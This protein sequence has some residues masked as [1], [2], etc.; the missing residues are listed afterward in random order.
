MRPERAPDSFH[1][2]SRTHTKRKVSTESL[3]VRSGPALMKWRQ[4]QGISRPLF[5][6]M[7]DF[8]E[9]K[10]ATYERAAT[11]PPSVRRPIKE[12]VRLIQALRELAGDDEAL[13]DWLRRPNRAFRQRSPLEVITSGDSHLIWAMIHQLRQGSFA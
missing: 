1:T 4:D 8:S 2:M 13:K 7:A 3:Q 5:A 10:L 6:T 9:R 11:I 12:T